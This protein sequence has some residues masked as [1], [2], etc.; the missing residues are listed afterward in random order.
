MRYDLWGSER[1]LP[2]REGRLL[3][4]RQR[5][6][7]LEPARLQRRLL[8]GS[9]CSTTRTP[10]AT[11]WGSASAWATSTSGTWPGSGWTSPACQS[12]TYTL[13]AKVD[14]YGFFDGGGRGNQCAYAIISFGD[15]LERGDARRA[16]TEACINDWSSSTFAAAHRVDARRP[17]SAPA[18]RP[19]CS[20]PTTPSRAARW[21]H[22]SIARSAC[23][24]D[25]GRL[26]R[27]RRRLDLRDQ[28][29][30]LAAAGITVGLRPMAGT[31]RAGR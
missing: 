23:R 21:R 12:G 3:L 26:L 17:A 19:S 30:P 2:R 14:P 25:A 10:S 28:H 4:P 7:Q 31:V 22:S 13:R 8:H 6:L 27:R 1:H 5:R 11:G 15:R 24:R 29:Q 20:A 18:A 9:M 16:A